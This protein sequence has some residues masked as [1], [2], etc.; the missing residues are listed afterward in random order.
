MAQLCPAFLAAH[1]PGLCQAVDRYCERTG[2]AFDAEPIN[3]LTNI[4]FLVAAWAAWRLHRRHPTHHDGLILALIV[5]MAV[6]GF[7]S[8]AFHT[9]ATRGAA[10][11][12]VIPI[13][14]FMLIYLWTIMSLFFHWKPGIKIAALSAFLVLT[15]L[16]DL[17]TYLPFLRGGSKYLPA[18]AVMIGIAAALLRHHPAA[19]RAFAA[20]LGVFVV[21]FTMR[22]LDMPL[23]AAWPIGTHFLW[24][25]LNA[26]LLYLLVRL[27]ILHAPRPGTAPTTARSC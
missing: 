14:I 27:A 6:I 2:P 4:G 23:C 15:A 13:V 10:L 9:V 18:I 5:N 11:L 22:S 19:G 26:V 17:G 12:D 1:S 3:A 20:A 16:L 21:S 7:G 8:F 24:H 25:L